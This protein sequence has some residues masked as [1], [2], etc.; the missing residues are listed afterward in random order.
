MAVGVD[1]GILPRPGC[2]QVLDLVAVFAHLSQ[3]RIS[4]GLPCYDRSHC[5]LYLLDLLQ[6]STGMRA[7]CLVLG[8]HS[9]RTMLS[10]TSCVVSV[11]LITATT[12]LLSASRFTNAG[13]NIVTDIAT[14]ALPIPVL[15]SLQLPKRQKVA[16]MAVFG[17]GGV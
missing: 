2:R 11:S 6:L 13:I 3:Y 8:Q 16:L 1:L 14:A 12:P 15:K 7:Y 10:P 5:H 9:I 17:L 4:P